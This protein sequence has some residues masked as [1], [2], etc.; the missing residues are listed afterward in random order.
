M[1]MSGLYH[2]QKKSHVHISLGF[3]RSCSNAEI[4]LDTANLTYLTFA[5]VTS[6]E[7][8]EPSSPQSQHLI[9]NK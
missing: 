2:E 8:R 4:Y 6:H 3:H 9:V 1:G 5:D 7:K